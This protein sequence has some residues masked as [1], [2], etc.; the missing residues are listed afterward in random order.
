MELRSI[1]L[2]LVDILEMAPKVA[3]L[4][5]SLLAEITGEGSLACVLAEVVPQVTA[6]LEYTLAVEVLTAEI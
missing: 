1:T 2:D 5:E 6:L 4:R 3:T